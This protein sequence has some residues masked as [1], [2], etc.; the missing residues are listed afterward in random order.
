MDQSSIFS[1]TRPLFEY[2]KKQRENRKFVESIELGTT[3]LLISFFLLFAI[4]PTV[5]IILSLIGENKAKQISV[6]QMRSKINNIILAQDNFSKIQEKYQVIQSSLPDSSGFS[7]AVTQIK[8]VAQQSSINISK[9]NFDFSEQDTNKNNPNISSYSISFSS[10]SQFVSTVNFLNRLLK[11]R[12]LM[13][14]TKIDLNNS[15]QEITSNLP[16]SN[17]EINF[18][19]STNIFYW[20]I[21]K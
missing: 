18:N 17:N 16:A 4:K 9:I 6:K 20:K 19:L 12:R 2:V 11:N 8:S 3:F 13:D 5:A 1:K 10:R 7:N 14:I 21:K 15:R